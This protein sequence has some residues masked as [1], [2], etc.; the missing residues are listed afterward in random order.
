MEEIGIAYEPIMSYVKSLKPNL[1]LLEA[2][3]LRDL[4][5]KF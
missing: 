2:E 5:M 1:L 4:S 3:S